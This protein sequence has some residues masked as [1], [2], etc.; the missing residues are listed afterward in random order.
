MSTENN[1]L[2]VEG[3]QELRSGS[4]TWNFYRQYGYRWKGIDERIQEMSTENNFRDVKGF[5]VL[6]NGSIV[7]LESD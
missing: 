6:G 1:F 4:E 3:F 5:Q 7:P 2:E